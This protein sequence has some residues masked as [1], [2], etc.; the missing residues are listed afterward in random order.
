MPQ[1][2]AKRACCRLCSASPTQGT[3]CQ[4][5]VQ[6]EVRFHVRVKSPSSAQVPHKMAHTC[7]SGLLPARLK[8]PTRGPSACPA[9][10]V[11][12]Q[13]A[14]SQDLAKGG[15]R[16]H[17]RVKSPSTAPVPHKR[18]MPATQACSP[19]APRPPLEGLLPAL[20]PSLLP[21]APGAEIWSR[22]EKGFP[23]QVEGK[24]SLH[25]ACAPQKGPYLRL[26]PA[27][28]TPQDQV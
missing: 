6:G 16:F 26:R 4:D 1:D 5:L 8:T 27:P 22:V 3:G 17:V 13:G 9:A 20:P 15:E 12:P 28:S 19:H 7:N 24:T 23:C 10:F 25:C 21:R 18:P 2:P 11:P 14:G